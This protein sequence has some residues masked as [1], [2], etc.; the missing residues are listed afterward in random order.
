M[1]DRVLMAV[2]LSVSV[3]S[4]GLIIGAILLAVLAPASSATVFITLTGFVVPT[5]A[6]MLTLLRA[7]TGAQEAKQ[8]ALLAARTGADALGRL[9]TIHQVNDAQTQTL[10][11]VKTLVNG[12]RHALLERIAELERQI[13]E[14]AAPE[15]AQPEK[16]APP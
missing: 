2:I 3:L 5:I 11:E 9:D 14:R 4:T 7:H 15:K 1:S 12:E 16:A 6:S 8:A 13:A 10:R